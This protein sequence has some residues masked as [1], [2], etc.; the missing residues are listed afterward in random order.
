[1]G[2][3]RLIGSGPAGR[4][5]RQAGS[6]ELWEEHARGRAFS[7]ELAVEVWQTLEKMNLRVVGLSSGNCFGAL[8]LS[9][10]E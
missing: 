6:L 3:G 2:R 5:G 9:A 8:G 10:A 7:A 4:S 1:M